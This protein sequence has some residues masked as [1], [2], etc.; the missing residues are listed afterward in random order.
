MVHKING[1]ANTK[2]KIVKIFET[3]R[4]CLCDLVDI[5]ADC[6]IT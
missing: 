6:N 1:D 4:K 5:C 3:C 2:C